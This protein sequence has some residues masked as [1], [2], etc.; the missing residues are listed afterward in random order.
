[1][2]IIPP[3]LRPGD[4]IGIT[5]PA[6]K[7]ERASAEYAAEVLASWGYRTII[8]NTAGANF[9]N[10]SATDKVRLQELQQMLDDDDMQAI[11]FGR[12]GYGVVRILD[13]IDFSHFKKFPKWICGY[14]DITALLIHLHT[15]YHT[16]SIHSLMCSGITPETK[17]DPFVRSLKQ[18]LSG[19]KAK[20][21]FSPGALNRKGICEGELIGGN[22]SLLANLSG[23][24]SQPDTKDKLLFVEDV[25]EYRYSVDRMMINLKRSGWLKDLSGLI[26]G[27]F[28]ESKETET[29]FGQTEYEMI[30]DKVKEYQYPVCFG[31]P[32]G[33]QKQNYAL[34]VGG[35]YR[36][37][38]SDNCVLEEI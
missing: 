26:I 7:M 13:R 14:S 6:S 1:M 11:L 24:V 8:G 19:E 16:A 20:C 17:D 32:V 30:W 33:H 22:L 36:L 28:N 3:Y 31:F 5:C 29:P 18:T 27:S 4:T 10:F 34:K 38:I 15:R 2:S 35:E 37:V 21:S 25:G 12:G 9:H 23:T